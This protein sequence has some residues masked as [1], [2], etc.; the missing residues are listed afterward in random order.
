M[1]K[2]DTLGITDNNVKLYSYCGKIVW[3]FHEQYICFLKVYKANN[4]FPSNKSKI[5][6]SM[7]S[8]RYLYTNIHSNIIHSIP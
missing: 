8:N 1:G 6:D 2:L 7:D 3:W 5:I 4:P